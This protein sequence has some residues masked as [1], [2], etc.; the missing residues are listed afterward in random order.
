MKKRYV[1]GIDPGRNTGFAIYDRETRGISLMATLDFWAAYKHV[2]TQY[3]PAETIVVIEVPKH[4]RLH[5]YQDGKT[6]DRL[7]EKIAGDVGGIAREAELLAD[8]IAAAGFEVRRV[9]PTRSKWT[10]KDIQQRTRI[11]TRTNEHVRDAISLC[12][13][14]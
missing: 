7:R 11:T 8:G 10:A 12:Y 2:S 5:E 9:T 4:S 14:L 1:I 13:G 3:E 6:G